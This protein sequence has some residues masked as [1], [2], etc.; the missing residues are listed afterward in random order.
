MGGRVAVGSGVTVGSGVGVGGRVAVGG[1]VTVGSGVS[2]GGRTVIGDGDAALVGAAVG[3]G[4]GANGEQ[5]PR[6]R[7]SPTQVSARWRPGLP[8][9]LITL[10]RVPLDTGIAA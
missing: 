9:R 3:C 8:A 1:G 4:A 2:D 10:S 7:A 6:S 5:A